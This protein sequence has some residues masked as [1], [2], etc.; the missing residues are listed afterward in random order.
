M[1]LSRHYYV[2]LHAYKRETWFLLAGDLLRHTLIARASATDRLNRSC[3][4]TL[5]V[6][7]SRDRCQLVYFIRST[8]MMPSMMASG[9][10]G[11][12]GIFTSTGMIFS[13]GPA[14]E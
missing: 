1:D 4:G 9:L 7:A 2:K 6:T 5:S 14:M 11:Q 3:E 13:T 8:L 10:G 12:P